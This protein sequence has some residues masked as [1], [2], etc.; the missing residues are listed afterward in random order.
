MTDFYVVRDFTQRNFRIFSAR[1]K[2]A[3]SEYF[4]VNSFNN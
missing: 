1:K 4:A 3:Q 2:F